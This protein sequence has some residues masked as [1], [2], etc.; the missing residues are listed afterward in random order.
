MKPHLSQLLLRLLQS[1]LSGM[2]TMLLG[3]QADKQEGRVVG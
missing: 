1:M 3:R 2:T